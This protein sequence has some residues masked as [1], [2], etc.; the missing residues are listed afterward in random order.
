M[1]IQNGFLKKNPFGHILIEVTGV[2]NN[3]IY[4]L[5]EFP[6]KLPMI[7]VS[8]YLWNEEQYISIF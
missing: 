7:G 5:F 4:Y 1:T 3:N 6:L 8:L 2:I